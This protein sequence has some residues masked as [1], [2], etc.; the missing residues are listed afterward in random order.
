MLF[1]LLS[2]N[3]HFPAVVALICLFLVP[4][5]EITVYKKQQLLEECAAC[6]QQQ[7]LDS[8]LTNPSL[9]PVRHCLL[10]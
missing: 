3:Q 9:V 1:F 5:I 10:R 6:R 8:H 7:R 2:N 4:Q